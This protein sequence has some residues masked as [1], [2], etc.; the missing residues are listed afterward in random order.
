VSYK[1][2]KLIMKKLLYIS[3]AVLYL[4]TGC[5][6]EQEMCGVIFLGSF[7]HRADSIYLDSVAY[8]IINYSDASELADNAQFNDPDLFSISIKQ[9]I[10][11]TQKGGSGIRLDYVNFVDGHRYV[12][13]KFDLISKSGN[14][15]YHIP[16]GNESY[17]MQNG[18]QSIVPLPLRFGATGVKMTIQLTIT[19]K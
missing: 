11:E 9:E 8:A 18:D 13:K 17:E 10:T 12:I 15:I 6:K 14:I 2:K 19:K 16:Y 1:F 3:F 7:A 5:N 4:S